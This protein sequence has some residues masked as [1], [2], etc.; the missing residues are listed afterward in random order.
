MKEV[1]DTQRDS[2]SGAK[3]KPLVSRE[4]V[5]RIVNI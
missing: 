1:L 5:A 2:G 4:R 3:L